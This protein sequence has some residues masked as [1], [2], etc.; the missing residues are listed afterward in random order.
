LK[1]RNSVGKTQAAAPVPA[2]SY[3]GNGSDM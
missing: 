2:Q 1:D 3:L